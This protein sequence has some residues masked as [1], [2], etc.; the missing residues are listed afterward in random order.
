MNPPRLLHCAALFASLWAGTASAQ[1][2]DNKVRVGVLTDLS[3]TYSDLAGQGSV[4]AAKLAIEDFGGKV[5]G[6]PI[7]I[8]SAD[9][10]NKGDIASAIARKWYDN[11]GVD[12]IF[13]LVTSATGIAVRE[14]SKE[15]GKID[16]NSGAGSTALTNEKCSPTGFHWA[17]DT[18]A[19]ANGTGNAVVK[20]GG[21]TWFFLTADYTF[22]Q[23]LQAQTERVIKANGGKVLGSVKHPFP[24]ADF[25]SFL[26]QAQGSGAKI[27]GL[28]NAGSD[29]INS[30]KQAKEFGITQGGQQL[31]GLLVFI[32]DVHSLGLDVAQKM[33][34]TTGFY[35]DADDQTRAF[36]KRFAARMNGRMPT[37]VHAGVYSSVRHYLKAVE[38][39]KTDDGLKV[40]DKM[41]ELPI[42][43]FFAKNGKLRADGR[44]VH[45]M[46]LVQ[47]KSPADSKAPWDYYKILR[48]IPGDEAF[49][50]L[51]DS[52][53]PLVKK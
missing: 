21:D 5:A 51:A 10:Q 32:S 39:A 7:D 45:D 48:T 26:L 50:P 41:R 43:D 23:N 35:W 6:L 22:G 18:Y 14:V 40:S 16:V 24:N 25:S 20:Q 15:K 29:T 11:D 46:Y 44:M 52:A 31:A 28:A 12:A 33:L 8:V 1:F 37:M 27:I 9:H 13:D 34:L 17:Y 19:L 36:A 38:A 49:Q 2:T 3:G 30:I 53:C 4:E 42:A 47:V